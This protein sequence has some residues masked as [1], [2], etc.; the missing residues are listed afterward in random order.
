MLSSGTARAVTIAAAAPSANSDIATMESG[1]S[2]D[3]RCS[4]HSSAQTTSTTASASAR[5][6]S[7]AIRRAGSAA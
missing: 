7:R 5:Q 1:S 6:K 2:D 4:V 3:R